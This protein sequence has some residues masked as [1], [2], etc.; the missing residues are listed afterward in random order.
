M[1]PLPE[2]TEQQRLPSPA[3]SREL[4][5][6]LS[7]PPRFR[8]MN[9]A[10]SLSSFRASL[11][12]DD[13]DGSAGRRSA[14]RSLAVVVPED[15]MLGPQSQAPATARICVEAAP[16]KEPPPPQP[17][18][19][20]TPTPP[21]QPQ[22]TPQPQP[23]ALDRDLV[24]THVPSEV[25]RSDVSSAFV[26]AIDPATYPHIGGSTVGL[27][28]QAKSANHHAIVRRFQL[29]R[30]SEDDEPAVPTAP[31]PES[32]TS[33]EEPAGRSPRISLFQQRFVK[34]A[35]IREFR[36]MRSIDNVPQQQQQVTLAQAVGR[37][38]ARCRRGF[39]FGLAAL[40]SACTTPFSPLGR[41]AQARAV[42]GGATALLQAFYL[43][44]GPV[45]VPQGCAATRWFNVAVD[46]VYALDFGVACNTAFVIRGHELETSRRRILARY[47]RSGA[48]FVDLAA[49]LPL[50]LLLHDA[51]IEPRAADGTPDATL[52]AWGLLG[53]SL[54][55]TR[56]VRWAALLRALW[57]ARV[58]R[59]TARWAY[60]RRRRQLVMLRIVLLLVLV[61]H[62]VACTWRWLL[63]RESESAGTDSAR[64]SVWHR[65]V[66]DLHVAVPLLLAQTSIA[67]ALPSASSSAQS[68]FCSAVGL[69]GCVMLAV[70]VADVGLLVQGAERATTQFVAKLERVAATMDALQLPP[71]LRRRIHE[72]FD[73]LWVEHHTLDGDLAW[74]TRELSHTLGL[75][76]QLYKYMDL[77]LH[78]P[79][80][81]NCSADFVTQLM[82]RLE[83][84]VY[85]PED[86][87]MREGE[88]GTELFLI[89]RG[90]CEL[91]SSPVA[92]AA[93]PAPPAARRSSFSTAATSLATDSSSAAAA[94]QRSAQRN[95]RRL[96][97]GHAF[98]EPAL[99]LNYKRTATVRALTFVEMCVLHR[100]A[101]QEILVR[102][103]DDRVEVLREMIFSCIEK[104]EQRFIPFPW[105]ELVDQALAAQ[106]GGAAPTHARLTPWEAANLLVEIINPT[107]LPDDSI[108]FG[109]R[110]VDSAHGA[111]LR[112]AR[113]SSTTTLV[114]TRLAAIEEMQH[115]TLSRL[116]EIEK[117]L[118]TDTQ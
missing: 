62:Y 114:E 108:I 104:K 56:F 115:Q 57:V 40:G 24:S 29:R 43:P 86:F 9:R 34:A 87:I 42:I 84:R 111:A 54:T 52:A 101:F 100:R 50:D 1:L 60:P 48:F 116:L 103:R 8:P 38:L 5:R 97:P 77:V 19:Q 39:W 61:T 64:Q 70:V 12:E 80:W 113:R 66:D 49:A 79:F 35:V 3:S 89:N 23:P 27:A 36:K 55:P 93:G 30:V 71:P 106:Q 107:D 73:H 90:V 83:V 88:I 20:P 68:V 95:V 26:S 59:V 81:R 99:L 44:L 28:A 65:Y 94:Q 53:E 31:L 13:A 41:V 10:H 4:G 16:E 69:L 85:L 47:M 46:V 7:A 17:K 18:L 75:E 117:R 72:Y 118:H 96:L 51:Q 45:Y 74:F 58:V 14:G 15:A 67:D 112:P 76:V 105:E 78:V 110:D 22:P 109:F 92:D 11:F 82:L 98:G 33:G 6:R 37:R 25:D 102:Y 2:S 91:R 21:A 32:D 63:V